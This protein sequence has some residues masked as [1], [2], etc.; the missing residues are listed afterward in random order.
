[1]KKSVFAIFLLL[2]SLFAVAQESNRCDTVEPSYISRM[3][4]F[5]ISNCEY[6]EFNEQDFSPEFPRGKLTSFRKGGLYRRISYEKDETVSRVVSGVQIRTNYLNAVLKAKG[7]SLSVNNDVFQLRYENK[8]VFFQVDYATDD[9]DKGYVLR[10]IE[11][12]AMKQ[13][14]EIS[15]SD[16]MKSDGKIAL[17]GILFDT[18]KSVIKPESAPALKLILDYLNENPA[19]K[20][21]V[22]G[23]TDNTGVYT[24]NIALSKARAK[25][26]KDYLIGKGISAARLLSEGVAS[27][28][29]VSTNETDEGRARNRRVEIVKQ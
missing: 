11:A 20:I 12:E 29:P 9:N 21:V 6:S 14:I 8:D 25:A 19:F 4:G 15:F 28:C 2:F 3:P 24:S 23:H 22:V 5:V 10:V 16:A 1:M 7:K 26:V 27:L 17:Y 13:D 18:G